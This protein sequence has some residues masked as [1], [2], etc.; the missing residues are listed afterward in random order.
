M[1]YKLT[2]VVG[3]NNKVKTFELSETETNY[4]N[5]IQQELVE[6]MGNLLRGGYTQLMGKIITI[7]LRDQIPDKKGNLRKVMTNKE[8]DKL[9]K[10]NR[11][12]LKKHGFKKTNSEEIK[13]DQDEDKMTFE[14]IELEVKKQ[15]MV[16]KE[17]RLYD[18]LKWN[19]IKTKWEEDMINE[20]NKI[21]EP[22]KISKI[23]ELAHRYNELRITNKLSK[24][25]LEAAIEGEISYENKDITNLLKDPMSDL[26]N[27]YSRFK[28]ENEKSIQEALSPNDELH[29][30]SVLLID[31]ILHHHNPYDMYDDPDDYEF[32]DETNDGDESDYYYE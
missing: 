32:D 27:S 30:Q 6:C 13:K 23:T 20:I 25:Y 24:S 3:F 4:L 14:E 2:S 21:V 16:K 5:S 9:L 28:E 31:T 8:Y 15:E 10:K 26:F 7:K 17:Q 18:E 1:V 29:K 19:K 12:S 11:Q 22:I